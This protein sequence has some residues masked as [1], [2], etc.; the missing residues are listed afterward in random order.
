MATRP[1][2]A[3]R[4]GSCSLDLSSSRSYGCYL[5][6]RG[7][8]PIFAGIGSEGGQS[9][10]QGVAIE[11]RGVPMGV[12]HAARRSQGVAILWMRMARHMSTDLVAKTDSW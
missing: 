8:V 9:V 4:V 10:C 6:G 11:E 2:V 5:E 7:R 12:D 3:G 1:A